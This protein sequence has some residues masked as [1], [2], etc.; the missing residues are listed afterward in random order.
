MQR[1]PPWIGPLP[2]RQDNRCLFRY[3]RMGQEKFLALPVPP[4]GL[5]TRG[6]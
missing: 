6:K 3:R 2:F 4:G 5:K 1:K